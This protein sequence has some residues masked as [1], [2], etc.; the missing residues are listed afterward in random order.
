MP[1]SAPDRSAP[2]AALVSASAVQRPARPEGLVRA[3]LY[4][5]VT[6]R[7]FELTVT[8]AIGLVAL[9]AAVDEYNPHPWVASAVRIF[10]PISLC[11]FV[12]EA[13]MKI[14]AFSFRKYIANG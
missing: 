12:L 1:P 8:A 7:R 6:S 9:S 11:I 4:D 3:R 5:V 14:I 10:N 13:I 2:H